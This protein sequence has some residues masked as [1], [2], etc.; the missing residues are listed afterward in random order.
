MAFNSYL[1]GFV[2]I[3]YILLL[4]VLTVLFVPTLSLAIRRLQDSEHNGALALFFFIP[5]GIILLT[6][7]TNALLGLF[8][9]AFHTVRIFHTGGIVSL[10]LPIMIVGLVLLIIWC[11]QPG[12]KGPNRFGADPTVEI[13]N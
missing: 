11:C 2:G 7:W 9:K 6:F 3:F 8:N 4:I 13:E 5:L 12:S 1:P 10:M